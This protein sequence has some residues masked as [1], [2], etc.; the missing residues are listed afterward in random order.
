ML[1]PFT[2]PDVF[3]TVMERAPPPLLV[4]VADFVPWARSTSRPVLKR[5]GR[6]LDDHALDLGVGQDVRHEI[7]VANEAHLAALHLE[8]DEGAR[9]GV[10]RRAI[11]EDRL[12]AVDEAGR[13]V[14]VVQSGV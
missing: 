1:P 14:P 3:C 7:E 13:Q 9:R 11:N 5:A 10:A 8:L 2:A 12:A 6:L 4:H